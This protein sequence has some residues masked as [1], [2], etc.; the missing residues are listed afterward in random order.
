MIN[1]ERKWLDSR[2]NSIRGFK[3][4]PSNANFILVDIKEFFINSLD[5]TE[6][7]L[8]NG[9]IIRDCTSFGLE[10]HIRVAVR[11]RNENKK[12]I[13]AFSKVI[14]EWGREIAEKEI[15]RALEK[16]VTARSRLNCEYYPCHFEGQDCT[17]CFCPFYPC[18]DKRTG[19]EFVQRSTGGEVWSCAGC[20]LIH[21]SEVADKVL[22]ALMKGKK[23]K[24]VW[25]II[26]ELNL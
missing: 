8:R 18:E 6:R 20:S 22:K 2:L 25:N 9:I 21:E 14:S 5:L 1:K 11:K 16:G 12:L 23:I 4:Y 10:N 13:K 26:M 24:E 3:T 17:F 19:G 7:M 15:G